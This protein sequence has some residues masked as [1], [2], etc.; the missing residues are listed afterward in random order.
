M[1][2]IFFIIL[3]T[4]IYISSNAQHTPYP[5]GSFNAKPELD[6]FVGTWRWV[7]GNDTLLVQLYKQSIHYPDPFN[8]DV[9]CLIGWHKYVQNG[10]VAESSIQFAGLPFR[11]GHSTIFAGSRTPVKLYGSFDDLTKNKS[12]DLYLTMTDNTYTQ[13]NWK[14]MESRGIT[15]QGFQ[16]GFTLPINVVLTKQ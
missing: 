16:Y 2:K 5:A 14:L 15:P 6:K 8:Y 10:V 1:K 13:M 11:G 9:E 3:L 12:C 7:S 4:G